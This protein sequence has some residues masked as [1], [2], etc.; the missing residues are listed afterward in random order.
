[1]R[2]RVLT[3]VAPALIAVVLATGACSSDDMSDRAAPTT[4]TA[5]DE[6]NSRFLNAISSVTT[7]ATPTTDKAGATGGPGRSGAPSDVPA[8]RP[9][10]LRITIE[11]GAGQSAKNPA[12]VGHAIVKNNG[13]EACTI[14]GTGEPS[15]GLTI[16]PGKSARAPF[17]FVDSANAEADDD[18]TVEPFR[19]VDS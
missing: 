16:E 12:T 9:T 19:P 17:R 13:A 15:E 10:E 2:S 7:E 1:M 3:T 14:T 6:T 5:P 18:L 11:G 8:C 4:P